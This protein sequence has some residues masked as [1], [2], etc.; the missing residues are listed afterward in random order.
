L[1]YKL[2]PRW[3]ADVAKSLVTG[4]VGEIAST[5]EWSDRGRLIRHRDRKRCVDDRH[6]R[7][8]R[9]SLRYRLIA[10]EAQTNLITDENH[11]RGSESE[12]EDSSDNTT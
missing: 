9:I 1:H 8:R 6:S 3:D 7:G 5:L 11:A 2:P 10:D 4:K 12:C